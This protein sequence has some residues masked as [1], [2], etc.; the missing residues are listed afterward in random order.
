M[1]TATTRNVSALIDVLIAVAATA[2][3]GVAIN[4]ICHHE[5]YEVQTVGQMHQVR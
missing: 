1:T 3:A 5:L 2:T 4:F